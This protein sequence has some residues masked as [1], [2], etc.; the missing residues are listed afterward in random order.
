MWVYL[1]MV[2]V[3]VNREGA[4]RVGDSQGSGRRE[5]GERG[6]RKGDASMAASLFSLC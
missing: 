5:G 2:G 6:R 3:G 1:G 4:A